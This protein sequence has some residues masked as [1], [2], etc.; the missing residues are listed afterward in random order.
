MKRFVTAL[1]LTGIFF[2][3][4]LFPEQVKSGALEGLS[5]WYTSVI[6]ILLPFL[7]LSNVMISTD[8]FSFFLRPLLSANK[9][10]TEGNPWI[11]YPVFLGLFC[12]FPMGAKAV[13]D[14]IQ[15]NRM[16]IREGTLLL[17]IVNQASPM[18]L[19]GYV[20]V[21]ILKGEISFPLMLFYLYL[22]PFIMFL[23]VFVLFR[24]SLSLYPKFVLSSKEI[25]SSSSVLKN[26][27]SM[28][29]N[30]EHTIW[31]AFT[32]IVT[33]GIY[34]MLFNIAA[35]L[36]TILLPKSPFLS[37]LLCSLE[38]STGLN[39]LS[40][41][42]FTDPVL[43]NGLILALTSFGG[44]C[45]AAQTHSIIRETGISMKSYLFWKFLLAMT[46]FFL[47]SSVSS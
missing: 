10:K 4:L 47:Y 27:N 2:L 38:F 21:H 12:G 26:K 19:A 36:C 43:K 31:N 22:P 32:V 46:V 45:T 44:F 35:R 11:I 18:F 30:L 15:N 34:M 16:T 7:I 41:L 40:S 42:N 23:F 14:L 1:L 13:T 39:Q 9:K 17:P 6:P 33:I 5:L 24:R 8:S 37:V 3:L 28:S 29:L 25:K 20:G